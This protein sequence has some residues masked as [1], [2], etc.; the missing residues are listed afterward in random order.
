MYV[1]KTFNCADWAIPVVTQFA[2]NLVIE[3]RADSLDYHIKIKLDAICFT[4]AT[5][6]LEQ[7]N[8]TE[9]FQ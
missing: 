9:T 2:L 4:I 6:F 7:T 1:I 5:Y 3:N 8:V